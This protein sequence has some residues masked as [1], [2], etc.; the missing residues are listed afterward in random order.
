MKTRSVWAFVVAVMVGFGF[1]GR[2]GAQDK[3]KDA[4]AAEA[5]GPEKCEAAKEESSVTDH[6]IRI[7]GQTIPYKATA[8]TTLLKNDK[9]D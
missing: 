4:K 9:G 5:K 3:D 6:M 8:S 1:A 2:V 7:G